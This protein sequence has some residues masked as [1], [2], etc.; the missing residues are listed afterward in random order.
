MEIKLILKKNNKI[1]GIEIHSDYYVAQKHK[2]DWENK[3]KNNKSLI[4][5][6]EDNQL[7]N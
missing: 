4:E 7:L 5:S 2:E 6:I 1:V 3:S